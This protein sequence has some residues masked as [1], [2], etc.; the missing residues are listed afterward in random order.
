MKLMLY[1]TDEEIRADMQRAHDSSK[2]CGGFTGISVLRDLD[3]FDMNLGVGA[4]CCA[5]LL[6]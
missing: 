4:S 5:L 1:S 6:R 3:Y 2:A